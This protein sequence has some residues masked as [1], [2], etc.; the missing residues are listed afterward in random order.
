[1]EFHLWVRLNACT[2]GF[3]AVPGPGPS[4]SFADARKYR[5]PKPS[6]RCL[7]V[8]RDPGN[9]VS[10]CLLVKDTSARAGDIGFSSVGAMQ[11]FLEVVDSVQNP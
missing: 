7:A 11:R 1:M 6:K 8:F 3:N 10:T 2:S 5:L 4:S 9:R